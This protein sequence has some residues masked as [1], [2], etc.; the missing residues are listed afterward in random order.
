MRYAHSVV[1][2]DEVLREANVLYA[3]ARLREAGMDPRYLAPEAFPTIQS[4]QVKC[5][6]RALVN[7]INTALREQAI[8]P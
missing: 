3:E 7:H 6:A 1:D 4:E 8:G 2:V 5:L